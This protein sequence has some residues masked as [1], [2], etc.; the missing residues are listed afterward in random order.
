MTTRLEGPR[1]QF[2]PFNQG[3]DPGGPDCGA[4]NPV[5]AGHRTAYLWEEVWERHSWLE[6]LGR[7]CIA[8]RDKT[9]QIRRLVFP[10]YHQLAVTRLLLKAVL[11]EGPGWR[12]LIQH[13][14]A[15]ARP[16]RSAGAPTCSPICTTNTTASCSTRCWW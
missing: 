1:T 14:P 10:R 3:S 2:L 4:G 5:M 15:P 8:E 9:K 16:P 13:P 12:Y 11:E 6:I 7:Y